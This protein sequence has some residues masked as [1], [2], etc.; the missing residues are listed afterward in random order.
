[1]SDLMQ[2]VMAREDLMSSSSYYNLQRL[3]EVSSSQAES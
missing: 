3:Q 2:G 1:M